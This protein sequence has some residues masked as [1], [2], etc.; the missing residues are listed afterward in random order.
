MSNKIDDARE[1]EL[2]F[3]RNSDEERPDVHSVKT[4]IEKS[5]NAK[6]FL[7]SLS[8]IEGID[9]SKNINVLEIGAGQCWASSILK[10]LHPKIRITSTDISPEAL[11]SSHIWENIFKTSID[12]KYPCTSDNTGENDN[13][14]DFIFTVAAAHHFITHRKTLTEIHRILK[15]DG[16]CAYFFEP[17]TPKFWYRLAYK[18]VNNNRP[19]VPEDVLV[20]S[21]LSKIADDVGLKQEVQYTPYYSNRGSIFATLF[22]LF[23]NLFPFLQ[24]LLPCTA[25]VTYSK[26]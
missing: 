13:S 3:W 9:F 14:V 26:L 20:L 17:V 22:F 21:K 6:I 19:E 1:K 18:R 15:K 23:L 11:A 16:K 2:E 8:K 24:R 4:I 5:S 7:D 10:S 12:K 25:T